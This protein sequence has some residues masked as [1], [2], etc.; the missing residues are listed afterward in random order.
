[1]DISTST[2]ICAFAPHGGHNDI[3]FCVRTCAEGG[4]RVLDINFCE[5]MNPSSRMRGSG[6]ESYVDEIG[7][8]AASLGVE[9]RQSH[10][11][12]YDIFGCND[13]S[14]AELMEE[15][16]RRSIKASGTL[17]VRW[18]VTHPGTVYEAGPDMDVSL[19]KNREYY[20][21]HVE[22]AADAGTGI[23][24]ENDFEYRSRPYQHI[25][26]S[27][28]H[29]LASLVD[30][31][32]DPVHVGACYDFGHANLVGGFFR[33]DLEIL[34]SR[35]RAVHIA[36]NHGERDEHLLPFSGSIDW[37][38]AMTALRDSGYSG[39]LTFEVQEFSRFYPTEY[40]LTAVEHSIDIGKILL[41]LFNTGKNGK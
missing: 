3:P 34:G 18:A 33:K 5:A 23:A 19:R 9:F 29:E 24:L 6:W 35:L 41:E 39:D 10:L 22:E 30:S 15:L 1:M 17:G 26:C 14:K 7:N 31:F 25:F 32:G 4:Y 27:N 16:I 21:P 38:E 12:Y 13:S 2:N 37:G 40:K 11:P 8:L 28:P 36:D 20:M